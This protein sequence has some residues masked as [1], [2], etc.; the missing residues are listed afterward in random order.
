MVGQKEHPRASP[1]PLL[2][3]LL[4]ALTLSLC[5]GS[6]LVTDP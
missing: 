4:G 6:A 1:Q 3:G 2:T 5:W